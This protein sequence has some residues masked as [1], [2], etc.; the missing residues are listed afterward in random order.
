MRPTM[1]LSTP[2]GI[3]QINLGLVVKLVFAGTCKQ[4]E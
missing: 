1:K 2:F 4:V 3:C